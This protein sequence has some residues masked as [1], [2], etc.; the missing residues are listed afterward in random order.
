MGEPYPKF[1]DREG[2]LSAIVAIP[3]RLKSTRFPGKVLA[4]IHG[5]HMIQ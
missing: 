1:S 4:K 3:A 2:F 5:K